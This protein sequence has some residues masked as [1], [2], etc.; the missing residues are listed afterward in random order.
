MKINDIE[1]IKEMFLLG[2]FDLEYSDS[3]TYDHRGIWS[4]ATEDGVR[5]H[6]PSGETQFFKNELIYG[7]FLKNKGYIPKDVL[8]AWG[9]Q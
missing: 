4:E 8:R 6:Y 5:E 7:S 2:V 1:K 3:F 9:Y